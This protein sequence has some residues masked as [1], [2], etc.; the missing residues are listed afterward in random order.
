MTMSDTGSM[1]DTDTTHVSAAHDGDADTATHDHAP[2]GEPLGPV[3]VTTWAY[4][5]GGSLVGVVLAL[6]MLIAGGG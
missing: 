1:S 4:A 5:I 2:A 6:A 3:D